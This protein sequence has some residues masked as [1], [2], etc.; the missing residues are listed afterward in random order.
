MH[1][2]YSGQDGLLSSSD[3]WVEITPHDTNE[4]AFKPKAIE[5][6]ITAGTVVMED[7]DGNTLTAYYNAGDMKP[8]RPTVITTASTATPIYAHK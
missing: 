1:D 6:G 4:L 5:V 8:H 2:N 7:V 3:K